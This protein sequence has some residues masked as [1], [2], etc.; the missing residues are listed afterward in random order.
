[1]LIEIKSRWS[2]VVLFWHEADGNTFRLTLE[3]AVSVRAD[4]GGANLLDADLWGA[5]LRDADL[6]GANLRGANLG[7]K[8]LIGKSP[9]L[10]LGPLGSRSDYLVAF[11]TDDGI[12][13]NAGCF[14]GTRAEFAAKVAETHGDNEYGREYAAA[15]AMIDAWSAIWTPVEQKVEA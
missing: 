15:L 4:L 3:T 1:V 11:L 14:H 9:V 12:Y 2:D 10:Q 6:G 7:G 8:T 5:N 13:I